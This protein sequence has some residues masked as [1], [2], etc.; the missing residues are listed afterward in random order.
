[1]IK[2]IAAATT[3]THTLCE[4]TRSLVEHTR[5]TRVITRYNVPV[6]MRNNIRIMTPRVRPKRGRS[7]AFACKQY[8]RRIIFGSSAW[9]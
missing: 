2:R 1:M 7:Y 8:V 3:I 4:I 5:L 9:L 6:A